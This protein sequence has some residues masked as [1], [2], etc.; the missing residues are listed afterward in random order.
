MAVSLERMIEIFEEYNNNPTLSRDDFNKAYVK[1][2]LENEGVTYDALSQYT[3]QERLIAYGKVEERI[4]AA[5][6]M[7]NILNSNNFAN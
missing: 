7:L 6:A 5:A 4:L 1:I 2:V 3:Y